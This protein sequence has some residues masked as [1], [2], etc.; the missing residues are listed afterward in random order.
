VN[1]EDLGN[2]WLRW[3]VHRSNPRQPFAA[4]WETVDDAQQLRVRDL[5]DDRVWEAMSHADANAPD[6]SHA[7]TIQE[8]ED[9]YRSFEA[10]AFI[11]P[12]WSVSEG[13]VLIDGAHRACA[14]YRLDP[15][16]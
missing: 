12:A 9:Q 5:A 3:Y 10:I 16:A 1:R 11:A 8:Y 4:I 6:R 14:I 13:Y 15:Y 2:L 7:K